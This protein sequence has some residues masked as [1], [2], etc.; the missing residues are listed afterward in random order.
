MTMEKKKK[1]IQQEK[2]RD[3]RVRVNLVDVILHIGFCLYLVF[4]A[5]FAR[6]SRPSSEEADKTNLLN[7]SITP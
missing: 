5:S 1:N 2:F 6:I 7:T 3:D 4:L